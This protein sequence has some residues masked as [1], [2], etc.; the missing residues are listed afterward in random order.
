M[1]RLALPLDAPRDSQRGGAQV[2]SFVDPVPLASA[3][4]AQVHAARLRESGK[5]VVLKVLKP[6]VESVLRT[7]LNFLSFAG[8]PPSPLPRCSY[9][10]AGR[11]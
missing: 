7:D 11:S 9:R 6:G 2:F 10:A 1:E 4:V 8:V 5:D 3:S